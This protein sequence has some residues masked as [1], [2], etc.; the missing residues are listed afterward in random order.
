MDDQALLT[1]LVHATWFSLP[2]D[3]RRAVAE[4]VAQRLPPGFSLAELRDHGVGVMAEYLHEPTGVRFVLIPGGRFAMGFTETERARML[5]LAPTCEEP[6]WV[7]DAFSG[8]FGA[9]P[10]REVDVAPMLLAQRPLVRRELELLL[11][12]DDCIS[13]ESCIEPALVEHA[14]AALARMGLRLPSEAE[15]EHA[16]RAGTRT[17]FPAG[18]DVL[19][20]DPFLPVNG[21]GLDEVAYYPE[22]CADGWHRD[23]EGAPSDARPWAGQHGV[24]RGG[25]AMS[26]P[27][28]GPGWIECLCAVRSN[29]ERAEFFVALRPALSLFPDE[30]AYAEAAVAVRTQAGPT[31]RPI[32]VREPAPA[33]TPEATEAEASRGVVRDM[34]GKACGDVEAIAAAPEPEALAQLAELRRLR[35]DDQGGRYFSGQGLALVD[36]IVPLLANDGS[37]AR[38]ELAVLLL[39]IITG[40][41]ARGM[42][43]L[44]WRF[45]GVETQDLAMLAL[46]DARTR[47][48]PKLDDPDPR[49]RSAIAMLMAAP[50][51]STWAHELLLARLER[52]E[53]LGVRAS[54]VMAAGVAAT[55][56]ERI[57]VGYQ[58]LKGLLDDAA[59]LV[60]CAAAHAFVAAYGEAAPDAAFDRLEHAFGITVP[61]GVWFPWYHGDL[62]RLVYESLRFLD[63]RGP[64]VLTRGMLARL[65]ALAGNPER[66]AKHEARRIANRLLELHFRYHG[67]PT[68]ADLQPA[69]REV[70]AALARDDAPDARFDRFGLPTTPAERR[71]W[72]GG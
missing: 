56:I 41:H 51:Q 6:E 54:L 53:D 63:E 48:L 62:S 61:A 49:V 64:A 59:P 8:P 50:L 13:H 42:P 55:G 57:H 31:T 4:A 36:V 29:L 27:W 2:D 44:D 12:R 21:F 68:P 20:E 1:K 3:Q 14:R 38:H 65:A 15:W 23:Y 37:S 5:E 69:Q 22:L 25:G 28:Q 45:E 10:V 18:V 11:D 26:W 43:R 32:P 40:D 35:F 17:L 24:L 60:A 16:C 34:H 47:L 67:K 70:L 66:E 30:V 33:A 71:A 39:D 58:T 52:E 46:I 9:E 19:P 72:L 7:Q